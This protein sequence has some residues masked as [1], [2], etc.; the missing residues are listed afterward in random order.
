LTKSVKTN[1]DVV[2]AGD[3]VLKVGK[4]L[5]YRTFVTVDPRGFPRVKLIVSCPDALETI[6]VI[7][8]ASGG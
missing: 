1:G 7:V 3:G 5:V 2:T 6:E 8:G 4:F